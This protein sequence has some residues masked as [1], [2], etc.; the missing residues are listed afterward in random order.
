M[1]RQHVIFDM[2][3]AIPRG[4]IDA[5]T[6]TY[7]Q[8][9]SAGLPGGAYL[10]TCMGSQGFHATFLYDTILLRNPL[11]AVMPLTSGLSMTFMLA[12]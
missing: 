1:H 6:G 8:A 2:A 4:R 12:C 7:L 11:A 10:L 3:T 5:G 9:C